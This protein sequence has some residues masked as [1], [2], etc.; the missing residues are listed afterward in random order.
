MEDQYDAA[1]ELVANQMLELVD[2]CTDLATADKEDISP[3]S[4]SIISFLQQ[5]EEFLDGTKEK[6]IYDYLRENFS[7]L[8]DIAS[9]MV[10][11]PLTARSLIETLEGVVGDLIGGTRQVS[12]L[13]RTE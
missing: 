12:N 4:S 5:F 9:S 7:T 10:R 1:L 6:H 11:A 8:S 2:K 3:K 13:L